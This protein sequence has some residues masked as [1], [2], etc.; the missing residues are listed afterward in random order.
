MSVSIN[1]CRE[2]ESC[3]RAANRNVLI[4]CLPHSALATTTSND[5]CTVRNAP[6]SIAPVGNYS[7]H[8]RARRAARTS[9]PRC[10]LCG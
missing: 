2:L 4:Y 1:Y 3:E 5:M 9:S 10:E 7:A 8:Q 6:P